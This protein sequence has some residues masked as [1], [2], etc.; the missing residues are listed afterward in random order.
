MKVQIKHEFILK[1]IEMAEDLLGLAELNKNKEMIKI[2]KSH[3]KQ[4]N[5]CLSKYN[6]EQNE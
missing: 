3:I 6:I 2:Y 5:L 4:G 1:S